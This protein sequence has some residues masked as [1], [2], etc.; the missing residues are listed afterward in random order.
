[1]TCP[2]IRVTRLRRGWRAEIVTKQATWYLGVFRTER[3][4]VEACLRKGAT[5]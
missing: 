5:L 4:A 1:M 3:E 2:K